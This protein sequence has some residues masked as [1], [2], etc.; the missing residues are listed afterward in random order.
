MIIPCFNPLSIA[1]LLYFKNIL[2]VISTLTY[3]EMTAQNM[4]TNQKEVE[5]V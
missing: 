5:F 2:E 1:N 3:N 4:F